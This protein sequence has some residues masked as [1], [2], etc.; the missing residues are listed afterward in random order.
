MG[1]KPKVENSIINEEIIKYKNEIINEDNKS[2]Y[3]LAFTKYDTY[4]LSFN[5]S[6]TKLF[7]LGKLYN[8]N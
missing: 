7:L 4:L 5:K 6:V 3:L 8:C 2:K 1:R